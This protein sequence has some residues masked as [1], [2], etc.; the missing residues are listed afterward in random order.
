LDCPAAAS[1]TSGRKEMVSPTY[2]HL[3]YQV[4]G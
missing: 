3:V 4:L 2:R 1:I